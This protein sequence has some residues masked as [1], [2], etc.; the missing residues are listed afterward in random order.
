MLFHRRRGATTHAARNRHGP[1]GLRRHGPIS[2]LPLLGDERASPASR[3]RR[4]GPMALATR[5]PQSS[6]TGCQYIRFARWPA[7][8][9]TFGRIEKVVPKV[10]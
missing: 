2:V 5:P 4:S 3:L 6:A 1:F 8:A 10:L 9:L 7:I